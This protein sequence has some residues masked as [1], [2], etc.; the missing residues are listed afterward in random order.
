MFKKKLGFLAGVMLFLSVA[1]Y[2]ICLLAGG[3]QWKKEEEFVLVTSFYPMYVLAENL[4]AGVEGAEVYNL[5]ENQTGCLHDYQ[6]TSKDMKLLAQA[7]AFLIHGAGM[8]LFMEK[9]LENNPQLPVIEASVGISLLEGQGHT[10]NHGEAGAEEQKTTDSE[11]EHEEHGTLETDETGHLHEENGHVW[12]DVKR[13]RMELSTVK[14]ALLTLLPEDKEALEQAA[15]SYDR[16]LVELSDTVAELKADTAGMP[17]VIF[18]EAFAYFAES[19]GMEVLVALSLDEET[20]PS[21][22]EIAEVI[23]EIRYH[24]RALILIEETYASYAEK[25]LAETEAEAVYLDPLTTGDGSAD[26]YIVG[27]QNNLALLE[28]AVQGLN[29]SRSEK[30]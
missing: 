11:P 26:S 16:K 19:L 30:Q 1:G 4:T 21:A 6:L 3:K 9:V 22:G 7:D 13:Y 28:E 29:S 10:H 2:I 14:E 17:V 18:H 25:I 5:T 27:M 8:E 12:M 20:V 23:E 24:G 15:A